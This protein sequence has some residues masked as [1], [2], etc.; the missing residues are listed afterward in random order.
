MYEK[1]KKN[2]DVFG[3]TYEF[4]GSF[5]VPNP[6]DSEYYD[7]PSFYDLVNKG[8]SPDFYDKFMKAE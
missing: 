3:K 6:F 8:M 1:Y 5:F 4:G 7:H 2:I